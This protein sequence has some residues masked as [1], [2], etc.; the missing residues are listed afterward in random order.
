MSKIENLHKAKK[1]KND[2]WYTRYE[3]IEKEVVNY[4]EQLKGL[5]IYCPCDDYRWSNF[6]KY[7]YDNFDNLQLKRLTATNY[8]IGEGAF[9]ADYDGENMTVI[10]LEGNGDF[11]SEECTKIKDECDLVCTNFPFSIFRD[12]FYWLCGGEFRK[13]GDKVVRIE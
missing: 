10:P 9:R 1:A 8:D 13:E 5:W 2:E 6:W 4:K 12:A 11:R 7:F 3:D